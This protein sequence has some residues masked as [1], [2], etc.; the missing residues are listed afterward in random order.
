MR[1]KR[2]YEQ[3]SAYE[4]GRPLA[5]RLLQIIW[6]YAWILACS[7]TPKAFNPWRL[8]WLRIFGAKLYG[9]PFVHQRARILVPWNLTMH[10]RSALGD[11]ANAYT[12]DEI[13][14][15]ARCTIAQEAYLCTGTHKFDDINIPLQTAKIVIGEDAFVGARAFVLPGVN[16]G[17]GS[18]IGACAVVA[19]D[20]PAWTI[21]AGNPARVMGKRVVSQTDTNRPSNLSCNP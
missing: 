3:K 15:K 1:A 21:S 14:L 19:A 10:H 12:L 16:I 11:R 20:V 18:V 2:T 17:E 5:G 6:D 13:E 7:W 4:S 9:T 8:F